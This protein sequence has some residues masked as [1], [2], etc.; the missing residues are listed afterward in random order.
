MKQI[1]RLFAAMIAILL[2]IPLFG[3]RIFAADYDETL[4]VSGLDNGD[5]VRFFKLVAWEPGNTDAV[6]GWVAVSP[7]TKTQLQ[8]II[9]RPATQADVDAGK[10]TEVGQLIEAEGITADLAGDLARAFKSV[11]PVAT[12]TA[13]SNKVE[14]DVTA[15]SDPATEGDQIPGPGIYMA[16]IT[17]TDVDTIYNP[18]FVSSDFNKD[19]GGS[20]SVNDRVTYADNA[21]AKKSKTELKK[22]A[23]VDDDT[24]YDLTWKSTRIGEVVHYTVTTV[25]PGYGEVYEAPFFKLS[26][27]LKD[28]KLLADTVTIVEPTGLTSGTDYTLAT[29][30]D[31][32]SITFSS[33]YLKTVK[34]PTNVKVTYD[35]VVT[36]DAPLHV[37]EELNEVWTEYSHDPTNESDHKFKR[38]TTQHYTYTIDAAGIGPGSSEARK[39]TSEVVK[40]GR[41]AAGNPVTE[42][43]EHSEITESNTWVSPLEGAEFALYTDEDCTQPYYPLDPATHTPTTTPATALSGSDGRMTFTGLD[44]GR[45]YLR[46]ESAPAGFIK[47]SH[48]AEIVIDATFRT[49]PVTEYTKDG[50]SWLSETEYNAL[51]DKTGYKSVTY[52]TDVL[53]TYTVT[54]DGEATATYHYVNDGRHVSIST[55]DPPVELPHQFVNTQGTELPDTG[56]IGTTL[57]YIFGGVMVLGAGI[58]LVSRQRMMN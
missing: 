17:P 14:L 10:A 1:K 3:T 41:D 40:V 7:M 52:D 24:S 26:D 6:G 8:T 43:T 50:T 58:L 49:V 13:A 33:A 11:T 35:A 29:A 39:K 48:V 36:T 51:A 55:E 9:G 4:T 56:G 2:V 20:W 45:Y 38:D 53:D 15:D 28:L 19:Q 30:D 16:V 57:F 23:E 32:Y 12:K 37:N 46:E 5:V 18:V 27:K 25:I 54:I 22:E 21:A 31:G 44:A 34:I 42:T 47:D